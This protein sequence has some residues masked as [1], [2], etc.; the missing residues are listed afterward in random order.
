MQTQR[1]D[2]TLTAFRIGDPD[3]R[4]PIFDAGGSRLFPGRWNTR[5]TP[6]IYAC[7]H[8]ATAMLEKLARGAGQMPENQHYV[9][10]VIDAGVS[11][12]VFSADHHPGWD[13]AVPSVSRVFGESWR[14]EARS[15]VLIVPSYVARLESNLLINPDHPDFASIRAGLP[16]PVWW[17][18]RLFG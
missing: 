9:R 18:E 5:S 16:R 3:G 11:F 10:I 14:R 1:L 2:R 12:E 15:A 7:E 4:F 17:D 13:S 6:A 8:Y